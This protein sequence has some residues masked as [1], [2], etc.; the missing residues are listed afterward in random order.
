VGII[1]TLIGSLTFLI[2]SLKAI[3]QNDAKK[4]LAYSTI[5]NLGLIITCASIGTQET[6]WAA[7]LLVIFHAVCKSLLFL[8]VGAAEHQ[9]GSRNVENME[10]LM[11]LST[12]ISIFMVIGIAGMFLAPFG[13]LISKWVAMKG[14]VDADNIFTVIIIVF[15]SA[16]TLFYWTKW[17]GKILSG[18]HLQKKDKHKFH[19]DE[20]ITIFVQ[21]II[22]II[23]CLAFPA[24]SKYTITP[25]LAGLFGTESVM[26][27]G[28]ADIYIMIFMLAILLIFP[29]TYYLISKSDKTKKASV[30][31]AGINMGD[32][33]SFV[34]TM[35]APRKVELRNWYMDDYFGGKKIT[36][37][38]N[39]LCIAILCA[40]VLLLIGGIA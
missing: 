6:L 37:W 39:I 8:T 31:M 26:P 25:Y 40:G 36:F 38:G 29:V 19:K 15:G 11:H 7:I 20:Y 18:A 35:G 23:A 4:I 33:E 30:Y 34:G 14:F 9:L 2:A 3:P 21:G 24:I 27:I 13:M 5:A 1:M 12:K 16:T 17:M 32:D 28:A 10:V 22:V